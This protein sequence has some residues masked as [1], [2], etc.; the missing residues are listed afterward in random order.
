M[1]KN[2]DIDKKIAQIDNVL[3][4]EFKKY[5]VH[6]DL[7]FKWGM[8]ISDI[9]HASVPPNSQYPPKGHPTS[10]MFSWD[11]GRVLNEYQIVLITHGKGVLENAHTGIININ[12]GD[13]FVLFPGEWHRYKPVLNTGWTEVWVGFHGSIPDIIM[14]DCFLKKSY[15]VIPNSASMLV[16]NL[17][18]SIFQLAIDEPFGY[19]KTI[20][21]ICM[22]LI[23]E[24]QNNQNRKSV[25]EVD[26]S[27]ISKAKY[28][29]QKKIDKT[30]DLELFCQS[31]RISYSK[32]RS[33]FK[34]QTG[35]APMQYFILLKIEKAKF[36]I[37][38]TD[39]KAKEIAFQLGFNSEHYFCRLFKKKTGFSTKEYKLNTGGFNAFN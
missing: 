22:Q 5:F 9:G 13:V 4:S 2:T 27:I 11:R 33:D 26:N 25:T 23:A 15:P 29:M 36:L 31:N 32:F 24:I 8:V 6:S 19:Q 28:V 37:R 38:N 21:S 14:K 7:D 35:L 20:S 16:M 10:H 3:K 39:L 34:Y 18:T 12:R 1:I 30:F 17:F